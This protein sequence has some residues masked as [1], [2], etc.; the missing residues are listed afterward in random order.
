MGFPAIFGQLSY[1][2]F[3]TTRVCIDIVLVQPRGTE[4]VL[5]DNCLLIIDLVLRK[6][7]REK[8]GFSETQWEKMG[9]LKLRV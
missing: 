5:I 3:I 7:K 8:T 2:A 6:I 4:S 1:S 9:S